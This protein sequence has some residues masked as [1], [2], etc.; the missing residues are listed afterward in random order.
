MNITKAPL[1]YGTEYDYDYDTYSPCRMESVK[2]SSE[3]FLPVLYLLVI[4]FGLPGNMLVLWVL[5]KYRRLRNMTDICL[6]NLAVSD[7]IFVVSL[8]F[9]AYFT[10]NQWIF[11][12]AL[13][14]IIDVLY[15]LGYY[16]GIMFISLISID[17]YFAIVHA[18]SPFMRRTTLHGLISSIAMWIIA[19]LA[20]LPNLL[21]TKTVVSE[22]RTICHSF[23]PD[24]ITPKW[25]IC[26]IF[27]NNVLG[28][29]IPLSVMLFCYINIVICLIKNKTNKH[30][31]I[32]VIFVVVITFLIFWTPH[33]IV[34]FLV[35]LKHLNI[36]SGCGTDIKLTTAQQITESITFVHC[37]LNPIIY[38]FLGQ[39]FKSD[40]RRFF[41][42][43]SIC[44][45]KAHWQD[46]F[47]SRE[48]NISVRTQ[49][50][51]DN[52]FSRLM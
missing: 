25:A 28:F 33:N 51:S 40:L 35:S 43:P 49:S 15:M 18:V 10:A 3:R 50:S 2:H 19:L 8:P 45:Y 32:K 29:L 1:S 48:F 22:G 26:M 39:K 4:L 47:T 12:D 44:R 5:L 34:L 46:Q 20:S 30:K 6:L 17:R 24:G 31:A 9:W 36:L 38:A 16:G 37:C 23:F 11:G 7:L 21:H 14:K 52:H 13:C 42:W 27:K 41:R